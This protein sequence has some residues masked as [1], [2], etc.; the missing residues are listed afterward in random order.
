MN[1]MIL[2]PVYAKKYFFALRLEKKCDIK[3]DISWRYL[4]K[5]IFE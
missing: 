1:S 2:T 4:I 3:R 5:I